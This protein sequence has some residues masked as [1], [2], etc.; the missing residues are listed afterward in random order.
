M[1]MEGSCYYSLVPRLLCGGEKKKE[2]YTQSTR[3][4]L[5]SGGYYAMF[6]IASSFVALV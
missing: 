5:K 1:V 6:I 2:W 4:K 3:W